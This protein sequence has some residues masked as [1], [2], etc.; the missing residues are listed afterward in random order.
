MEEAPGTGVVAFRFSSAQVD[1]LAKEADTLEVVLD[2]GSRQM[3][4][5][6]RLAMEV[7]FA[8]LPAGNWKLVVTLLR[9]GVAK[10][11]GSTLVSI[12]PGGM[13]DAKV[14]LSAVSGGLRVEIGFAKDGIASS[15]PSALA[16]AWILRTSPSVDTLA[17]VPTIQLD[18]DGTAWIRGI[19]WGEHKGTWM[20]D[21]SLLWIDEGIPTTSH[22]GIRIGCLNNEAMDKVTALLGMPLRWKVRTDTVSLVLSDA[23]ADTV[24]A[25][26]DPFHATGGLLRPAKDVLGTWYLSELPATGAVM[27]TIPLVLSEDGEASGSDG[28]NYW[29]GKWS[30][31]SDSTIKVVFGSTTAMACIDS[32]G[33]MIDKGYKKPLSGEVVWSVERLVGVFGDVRRLTLRNPKTGIVVGAY[34]TI[35]PKTVLVPVTPPILPIVQPNPY[36]LVG[37]WGLASMPIEGLDSMAAATGGMLVFDSLGRISG[38]IACNTVS[39]SWALDVDGKLLVKGFASTFMLC[40]D[41]VQQL[42]QRGINLMT[43]MPLDWTIDSASTPSGMER[44]TVSSSLTGATLATFSLARFGVSYPPSARDTTIVLPVP[45]PVERLCHTASGPCVSQE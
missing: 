29:T 11:R 19:C 8:D 44:V 31:T 10:Y 14:V 1:T 45:R 16:R 7:E 28:C 35:P 30:T 32:T 2:N 5:R 25:V 42:V 39:G 34:S 41:S 20:A 13:T 6:T 18:S 40:G 21:D 12:V 4:R 27:D 3:V 26:F 24:L 9:G 22:T 43:T 17:I 37:V 33:A 38:N 23:K 15:R 36:A